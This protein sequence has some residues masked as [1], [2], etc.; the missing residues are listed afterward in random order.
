MC[1]E[2]LLT[3]TNTAQTFKWE[4]YGLTV[5][6]PEKS[7]PQDTQQIGLSITASL[8]GQY[9]FPANSDLVSAVYWFELQHQIKQQ[10]IVE[11]QHCAKSENVSNLR[12]VKAHNS[13]KQLPYTFKSQEGGQFNN[14]AYAYGT[15]YY[16]IHTI[17][18][19]GLA[20]VQERSEEK[21]YYS[22]LFHLRLDPLCYEVY[23]AIT[24][25]TK[26]HRTVSLV[27]KL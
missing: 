7:L 14:H 9:E 4:G 27:S 25:N 16:S 18:T 12:F 11:I 3:I 5:H 21:Y 20:I 22:R 24:L 6:I 17:T 13:Q 8:S 2:T 1:G 23:L 15:L 10:L 26:A 19:S